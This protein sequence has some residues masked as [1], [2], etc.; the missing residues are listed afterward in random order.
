MASVYAKRA[1]R[2]A[3]EGRPGLKNG[4]DWKLEPVFVAGPPQGLAKEVL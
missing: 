4:L 2:A 1:A 3:S